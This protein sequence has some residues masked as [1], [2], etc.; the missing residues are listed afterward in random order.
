MTS[1]KHIY[2][3]IFFMGLVTT[4]VFAFSPIGNSAKAWSLKEAAKPYAGTTI[5]IIGEALA[6]LESLNQQK[7]AFESETGIKVV[8]EQHAFDQVMQKTTADFVGR[9]GFYDAILNPHVRVPTLIANGWIQPLG[10]FLSNSALADP[11]FNVERA[12]L[13]K[14]WLMASLGQKGK[15][16]GVPFSGHTI[17]LNWRW[18]LFEHPDEQKAF[19]TKYGY[20]L[21]SPPITLQHMWD[22]AE[23]F[24]RKQGQ[25]LAGETLKQNVFGIALSGKRHISMLWN[26]YNVLYAFDGKVVDS[27][28]GPDYGPMVINSEAGIAALTY[29]RDIMN[30]FGPTGSLN[31]TWDEQLAAMQSG[32]AVQALL[33]AD[34]SYAISHDSS[35]SR[36][37]GK[38]AYS[39]TPI[40]KRKIVNLHQWGMF[41]PKT[42]KNP[43]AAWLFLQW[44]QRPDV[45]AK[46]MSTGSISLTKSAY[47]EPQVQQLVYA[48]I[49]YFLL[50]GQVPEMKG[51]PAY[52]KS[53]SAWGI[54][55]N[56]AE[57]V[58]PVTKA[59]KP[60][61]FKLENFP[62]YAT[63]EEILQKNL[64]AVFANQM[65]PKEGLDKSVQEIYK[66]VPALAKFKD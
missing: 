53:G 16:Y 48:A 36:V 25:K 24:T 43:E 11:T 52:R 33:W 32:L 26:F 44:A 34:A 3:Q 66:E 17:Y 56:Y 62:E 22:T 4:F 10:A 64:S 55:Q 39:G 42:S 38:V 9:T 6:P 50:S 35:Q 21:P 29:Y 57:A 30:K 46:L 49:N 59:S 47:Q 12:V 61:I 45:Q 18:D 5:R 58:D 19:E 20:P 54:P 15:L 14:D 37:V 41:I 8:I 60:V 63:V 1:K 27:S 7:H 28:T 31:Y 65:S 40:G 51:A 23:F 13:S 2:R